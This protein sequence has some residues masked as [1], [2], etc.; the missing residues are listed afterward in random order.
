MNGYQ[1]QSSQD[2]DKLVVHNMQR[3]MQSHLFAALIALYCFPVI[4]QL[5]VE[6]YYSCTVG[7]HR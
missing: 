5:Q 3:C 4:R 7:A 1:I 6:I 2:R